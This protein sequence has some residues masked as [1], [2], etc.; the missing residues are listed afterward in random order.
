MDQSS[1]YAMNWTLL[2]GEQTGRTGIDPKSFL[3]G[4][5]KPESVDNFLT[6]WRLNALGLSYT[7][8]STC[9]TL[10][11]LNFTSGFLLETPN[12]KPH[13]YPKKRLFPLWHCL[14]H[15]E[16]TEGQVWFSGS[17]TSVPTRVSTEMVSF[18]T[19]VFCRRHTGGVVCSRHD[20]RFRES[21]V[22]A[23]R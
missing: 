19:P 11:I 15:K 18:C 16:S 9:R 14:F 12:P 17:K 23:P 3:E 4:M 21:S 13:P 7:L 22:L 1:L 10:R 20:K 2:S 5:T 6:P 8:G